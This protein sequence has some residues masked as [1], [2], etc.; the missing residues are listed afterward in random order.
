MLYKVKVKDEFTGNVRELEVEAS[1]K[2]EAHR[3]ARKYGQDTARLDE[4]A[5]AELELAQYESLIAA[6]K[7]EET[8]LVEGNC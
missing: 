1:S 2:E 8:R 7:A 6:R 5:R 4:A 3:L